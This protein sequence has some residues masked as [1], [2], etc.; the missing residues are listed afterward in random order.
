[1]GETLVALG[2]LVK[3]AEAV[4]DAAR[5]QGSIHFVGHQDEL[6]QWRDTL[7]AHL[8]PTLDAF[9]VRCYRIANAEEPTLSWSNAQ[10]WVEGAELN[11]FSEPERQVLNLPTGGRCSRNSAASSQRT[12]PS[13]TLTSS[14][15]TISCSP[16]GA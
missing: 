16:T 15:G 12:T 13:S 7:N 5:L 2:L 3:H 11:V 1:L 4:A 14:S 6:D 8:P 10:G 9:L